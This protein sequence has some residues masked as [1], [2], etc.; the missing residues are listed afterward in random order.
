VIRFPIVSGGVVAFVRLGRVRRRNGKPDGGGTDNT[1]SGTAHKLTPR[2]RFKF[3]VFGHDLTSFGK[4][5]YFK[6]FG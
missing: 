3:V 1:C 5:Q 6:K 2:G 4:N